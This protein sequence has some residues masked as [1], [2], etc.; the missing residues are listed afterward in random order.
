MK[1]NFLSVLSLLLALTGSPVS[2][3]SLEGQRFDD[4]TRIG[5]ADLVLNGLGLRAV[6]IIKGYVAGLYLANKAATLE[7]VL[8]VPGPKRLQLRMLREASPQDFN[9]ALVAGIRKNATSAELETLQERIGQLERTIAAVG[10]TVKGD[11][12]NLDFVP[13]RG[14]TLAVNGTV[15]GPAIPGADFFQA[16][17]GIFVGDNPVDKRLKKGLLGQ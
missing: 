13:E 3:A 11:T 6:F 10:T 7:E 1:T 15:R 8:A 9:N 12:I 14:M 4:T 17:L 2:A 5:N 16:V